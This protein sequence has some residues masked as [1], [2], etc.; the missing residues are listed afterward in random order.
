M[1][2]GEHEKPIAVYG[3]IAANLVIA[4]A[5]FVAAFF[6]GSSSML[7]EAIHSV[8]DTGNEGLLLL[9]LARSRRPADERHPFDMA[10]RSISGVSWWRCSCSRWAAACRSMRA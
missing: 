9:G 4:V 2:E 5:K 7:S 8:V 3:A 10:R 6:T 1:A